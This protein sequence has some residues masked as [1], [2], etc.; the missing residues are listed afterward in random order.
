MSRPEKTE[1]DKREMRAIAPWR[2][3]RELHRMEREMERMFENFF[4]PRWDTF[5][6]RG[7][8]LPRKRDGGAGSVDIDV[9]ENK[10]EVVVKAELPGMN[11]DEIE[12]DATGSILTI[13]G[14]KKQEEETRDGQYYYSERSYGSFIRSL[15]LPGEVQ[16]DNVKASL[17]N[18]VL[19]IRLAKTE[20]AKKKDTRITVE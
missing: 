6:R 14:E 18:G 16:T 11:K 19:E 2:S 4:R 1:E 13:K 5:K 12:V 7:G 8:W 20:T 15:E 3:F 9:Y 10:D 17:N